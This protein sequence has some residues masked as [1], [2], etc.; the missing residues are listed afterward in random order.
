MNATCSSPDL[1]LCVVGS[2]STGVAVSLPATVSSF[3]PVLGLPVP[4]STIFLITTTSSSSGGS[5]ASGG[6]IGSGGG[7]GSGVL[8]Q[9]LLEFR[10]RTR[11][12]LVEKI[13]Q[14]SLSSFLLL[15]SSSS[16]KDWILVS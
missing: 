12:K 9:W 8:G 15:S 2:C 5:I 7:I 1:V 6:S 13:E 16:L 3:I 10:R 14:L 4:I 11:A